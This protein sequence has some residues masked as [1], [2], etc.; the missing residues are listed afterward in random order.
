MKPSPN[1][2]G[3]L[4]TVLAMNGKKYTVAIH[5]LVA[6]AFIPNPLNL[7]EVNHKD[8]NK[9]NNDVSNLEWT[10]H[11]DNMIH[12]NHTGLRS[13]IHGEDNP[14]NKYSEETIHQ[15]CILLENWMR[16][17]DVAK[18]LGVSINVVKSVAMQRIWNSVTSKYNL[19]MYIHPNII[20]TSDNR[21]ISNIELLHEIELP[22]TI[23]EGNTQIIIDFKTNRK[24][25]VQRSSLG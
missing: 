15:I 12:A 6:V 7:P 4:T 1:S 13:N 2:D 11:K 10:S 17:V 22:S 14:N 25:I 8:G 24:Y 9:L 3:Y 20:S 16:P 21:V 5:R 18:K 23:N 19:P